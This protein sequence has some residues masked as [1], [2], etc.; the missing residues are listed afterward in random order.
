MYGVE[1]EISHQKFAKEY[2]NNRRKRVN[3]DYISWKFGGVNGIYPPSFLLAVDGENVVG[4]LGILPATIKVYNQY[5]E[6][7]WACDLMVHNDYRGYGIAKLLYEEAIKRKITLGSDPSPA[8]SKS[9]QKHG[10]KNCLGPWKFF[11]PIKLNEISDL[12]FKRLSPILKYFPNPLLYYAKITL[13]FKHK[14][15][16]LQLITLEEVDWQWI[17]QKDDEN[18]AKVLHDK[19]F[20]SWRLAE[21]KPYH[22][23]G[24]IFQKSGLYFMNVRLNQTTC[25]IC[26]FVYQTIEIAEQVL[27]ELIIWMQKKNVQAIRY[28]AN[29]PAETMLLDRLGFIKFRTRT[30]IIYASNNQH[31]NNL[32]EKQDSFYYTYLDSDEDI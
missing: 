31:F 6:A 29:T 9:M 2:F 15:R 22:N 1:W 25:H 21:F 28:M 19:G 8:A 16:I 14:T 32:I 24:F 10:F 27:L 3:S 30:E 17:N 23:A 13:F 12:K 4:Q 18:T 20:L 26:D 11:F 5:F 7:H